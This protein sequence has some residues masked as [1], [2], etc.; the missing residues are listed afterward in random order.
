MIAWLV[1]YSTLLYWVRSGVSELQFA[2]LYEIVRSISTA[3]FAIPLAWLARFLTKPHSPYPQQQE[4]YLPLFT[5]WY[6]CLILPLHEISA[7][8]CL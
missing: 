1:V 7:S 2:Q 6:C 4:Y 5:L 8:L 3:V